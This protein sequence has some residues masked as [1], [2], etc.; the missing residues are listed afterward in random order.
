MAS[1]TIS[2][3]SSNRCVQIWRKRWYLY[4]IF[5]HLKDYFNIKLFLDYIIDDQITYDDHIKLRKS[6]KDIKRHVELTKMHKYSLK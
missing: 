5:L 6:W 3:E 4:A 2:Y 1:T